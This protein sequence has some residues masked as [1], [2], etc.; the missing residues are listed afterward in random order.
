MKASNREKEREFVAAERK[1]SYQIDL[2]LIRERGESST[3]FTQWLKGSCTHF[4]QR[5]DK[6]VSL[7]SQLQ[8]LHHRGSKMTQKERLF[9]AAHKNSFKKGFFY[10]V[11]IFFFLRFCHQ[12]RFI[13]DG[14]FDLCP[15]IGDLVVLCVDVVVG[16]FGVKF[17]AL[18]WLAGD[19][20]LLINLE[21]VLF[22]LV[23]DALLALFETVFLFVF[24]FCLFFCFTVMCF[25]TLGLSMVILSLVLLL[26]T[27]HRKRM[28]ETVRAT[29]KQT[30]TVT[31]REKLMTVSGC[32]SSV[33]FCCSPSF[34]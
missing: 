17:F 5:S 30:T 15:V 20:L 33:L 27:M 23:V 9:G 8:S 31:R 29:K 14:L 22:V 1:E 6:N 21:V 4:F 16:V 18:C 12:R 24:S 32:S 34:R 26:L 11:N 19:L 25:L 3:T 7:S 2:Q 28:T 13:V 10:L